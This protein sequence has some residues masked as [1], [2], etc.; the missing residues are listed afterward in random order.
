MKIDVNNITKMGFVNIKINDN[1]DFESEINKLKK[2]KD[3]TI[4]AH[5][6][7]NDEIQ[8]I[9]DFIGD[10]LFLA[11]ITEKIKSKTILVAGVKFMAETVKILNPA[12]KVLLPDLNSGCSLSDSCE[13]DKFKKFLSLYPNH[14]VVTYVNTSAKIKSI[15]DIC[16]TSSNAK[17]IV[18]S[19]D[20]EQPLIFAPDKNLGNYIQTVTKRL[21]MVIWDG[22]CHVHNNFSFEKLKKFKTC[23]PEALVIA[24]PECP[25]HFLDSSNFIGSTSELIEFVNQSKKKKFIILTEPG[26]VF[27]LKKTNPEKIFF[28][29]PSNN[30]ENNECNFMRLTTLKKLYLTLKYEQPEIDIDSELISKAILP[31]KRM[32]EL[33]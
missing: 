19:F 33:S 21:N 25:K 14:K 1:F 4:L 7:Q 24:H 2:K 11:Q 3:I 28:V 20:R 9:A 26:V 31:I 27:S 17:K 32:L 12:K 10:S 23:N 22:S 30:N 13:Y 16:C 5:Y 15:S 29:V 8:K 18:N 6:Y